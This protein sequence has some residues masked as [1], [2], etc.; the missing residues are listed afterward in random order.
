MR[1]LQMSYGEVSNNLLD[2][3]LVPFQEQRPDIVKVGLADA[4]CLDPKLEADSFPTDVLGN[5]QLLSRTRA[6][7][8]KVI[9]QPLLPCKRRRAC[10]M[11]MVAQDVSWQQVV[12]SSSTLC[13][14]TV[15]TK[16]CKEVPRCTCAK[17]T[18]VANLAYQILSCMGSVQY[19]QKYWQSLNLAPN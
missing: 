4:Q 8:H 1:Q 11:L 19:S 13:G 3:A 5:V 15:Q 10:E 16:D 6:V 12:E 17:C 2:D 9:Q 18:Q 7:H 14:T